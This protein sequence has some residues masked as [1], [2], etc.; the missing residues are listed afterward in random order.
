MDTRKFKKPYKRQFHSAKQYDHWKT[1]GAS[2]LPQFPKTLL[3]PFLFLVQRGE[4]CTAYSGV[5][6]RYGVTGKQYDAQDWK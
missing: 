1:L 5:N 4:T 6:E 3:A 2:P